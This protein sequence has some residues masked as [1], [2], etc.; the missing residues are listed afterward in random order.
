[1]LG[2]VTAMVADFSVRNPSREA[3]A[4]HNQLAQIVAI[5]TELL[6]KWQQSGALKNDI[7]HNTKGSDVTMLQRMLSQDAALYP[8]KKLT[9]YYGASTAK[10]VRA[11]QK[12][13]GIS[14]S[15]DVD[16]ETREKINS[17]FLSHLCPEPS[18]EYPDFQRKKVAQASPLPLDYAP[19]N[20]ENVS[21][22]LRT[23][24]VVCLRADIVPHLE[25]MMYAAMLDGVEI[26]VT[27]G[28]RSPQI[29]QYI[30]DVWVKV[31]GN[32]A[33]HEVAMPGLS[34]HQLGTT[35]D[36]TD[37]SIDNALVDDRFAESKGGVWLAANAY[38]YGFTMSFP[39]DK[40]D[41]TG[42]TYEPWHWRYVGEDVALAMRR[43]S[44][45]YNEVNFEK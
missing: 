23:F 41:V 3:T 18:V 4:N 27:S 36:L 21:G 33:V 9:G 14:E 16:A 6:K 5:E 15:G 12:E 11:F 38:K 17:I 43:L 28:F 24:G 10:A 31:D 35:V 40:K 1:M 30:H 42:F 32:K 22:K 8:E 39:K 44:M 7:M 20:L 25:K 45:T 29:Q 34:E 19:P 26:M 2:V 37:A 13:Y